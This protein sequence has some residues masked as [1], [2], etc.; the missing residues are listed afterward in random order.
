MAE[1]P[2]P[3][4]GPPLDLST[5]QIDQAAEVT[6]LDVAAAQALWKHAAPPKLANL[7][8]GKPRTEP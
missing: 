3:P 7:L 4:V 1:Q 8:D 2:K 6:P 5:E